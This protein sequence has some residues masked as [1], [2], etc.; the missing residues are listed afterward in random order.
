MVR[1]KCPVT[2]D[3]LEGEDK[4][5]RVGQRTLAEISN[6]ALYTAMCT[7]MT[8]HAPDAAYLK[9]IDRDSELKAKGKPAAAAA[10]A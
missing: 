10:R 4:M 9:Q 2:E 1:V 3:A 5:F 6:K 8:G 7:H